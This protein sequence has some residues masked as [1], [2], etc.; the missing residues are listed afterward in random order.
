MK[1]ILN[2]LSFTVIAVM[3]FFTA[4]ETEEN[5][6]VT[7]P[8]P[9]FELEMPGI[10]NVFLNFSLPDNPAFTITWKDQVTSSSSYEVEMATDDT[11]TTPIALGSTSDNSFSMTVTSF[12]EAINNAGITNFDNIPVFMR[13]KAGDQTSNQILFLVTTY[14]INAPTFDSGLSDGDSF[15]L[16]LDMN[17]QNALELVIND[18]VLNANIGVTVQYFLEAAAV[19]TN[20]ATIEE[21]GTSTDNA[22]INITHAKLNTVAQALGIAPDTTGDI[23]IRLRSVITNGTSDT[24]ERIGT[25]ITVTV[26]TYLTVLDL[27]TTWGIVGSAANDWGATP[28][29]PFFKTDVDGVLAAYVT[30]IDGE[31]KFREN[32]DWAVNY[33]D[34]GADGSIELNGDNIAVTAG[35][36]KVTLNFNDNTYTLENFS[37]GIVGSAYNDWGATPDFMLEYDQYSDV[38]RG[39]VTL[40]DGEMKLRMNND[41]AVNYGDTGADGSIELNGDNIAVTAGIYIV[42]VDLNN[43]NYTLEPI[44]NVWGLVGS[45]FNDWGA[46]PDAQFTRD[47]SRPFGDVWILRDVEL[48]D[49]EFKF[50]ANNDWAVNYGDTGGDGTLELGGDNL[51]ATAGTYTIILDFSDAAN[52]TYTIQ[53]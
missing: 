29:L 19:G 48:L 52:P 25:P 28:D 12:N 42:T 38:F 23:E 18:P 8:D 31:I 2:K 26:G 36:Y 32:N 17:D 41:W 43:N 10:S 3:L 51:T 14:P 1:T 53:P 49:G 11:F 7:S 44:T 39:I 5:I 20:F 9:T 47:W 27:S 45:A 6:T 24:L 46:T 33:G 50:R 34:T 13:V 15:T 21:L 37:L 22:N 40:L 35:S 4:C 16:S 30:L